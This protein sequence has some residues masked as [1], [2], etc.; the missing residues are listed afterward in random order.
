MREP[1]QIPDNFFEDCKRQIVRRIAK[2]SAFR[3]G[4]HRILRKTL[5]V[6]SITILLSSLI[7]ISLNV[8]KGSMNKAFEYHPFLQAKEDSIQDEIIVEYLIACGF[9]SLDLTQ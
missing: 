8:E 1:Y 5:V 9:S 7:I 6:A 4:N 2:E 3:R